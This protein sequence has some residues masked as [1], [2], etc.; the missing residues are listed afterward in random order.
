MNFVP[1]DEVAAIRNRI[2]H[3]IIDSDGHLIEYLPL[4]RDFVVEEAGEDVA[5][6]FDRMT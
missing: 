1:S 4:V 2:E 5:Q 6:R 3:P